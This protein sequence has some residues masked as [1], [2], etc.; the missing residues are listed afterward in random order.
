MA[1]RRSGPA[2]AVGHGRKMMVAAAGSRFLPVPVVVERSVPATRS[3]PST[4]TPVPPPDLFE[5]AAGRRYRAIVA[6]SLG[7]KVDRFGPPEGQHTREGIAQDFALRERWFFDQRARGV[8]RRLGLTD[9]R[10]V[11]ANR[12]FGSR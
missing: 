3:R 2:H 9:G 11:R 1:T 12:G 8:A 6:R 10:P 5:R 4:H 7:G